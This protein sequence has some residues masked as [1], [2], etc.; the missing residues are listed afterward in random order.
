MKPIDKF[1]NEIYPETFNRMLGFGLNLA[2][3]GY[4][5]SQNKPN[6]F[7]RHGAGVVFF[8]DMR[9]TDTVPIWE[10][11][12]P[13]LY[14][15]FDPNT[16]TWKQKR[17]ISQEFAQLRIARFSYYDTLSPEGLGSERGGDG[18]CLV[19]GRDFQADGDYCSPLCAQADQ[20][21]LKTRC[22]VCGKD[23]NPTKLIN[24]HLSYG[25][26]RTIEVCRSCHA[27]IHMTRK[28]PKLKPPNG[29]P[30]APAKRPP[31]HQQNVNKSLITPRRNCTHH[32]S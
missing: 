27:K 17:L 20:E 5:E 28:L 16:P 13:L 26:E 30:T 21:L 6:L 1:G 31:K 32:D 25:E 7:Y 2:R 19:C 23:L 15:Q 12:S 11:P 9:G 22:R 8:A 29:R 24:H 10:D 18:Y 14:A 3:K 4:S